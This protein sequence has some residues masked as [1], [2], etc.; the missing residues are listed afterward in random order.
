[1]VKSLLPSVLL[2]LTVA[3]A[4]IAP[5]AAHAALR[6]QIV[7]ECV[8]FQPYHGVTHQMCTRYFYDANGVLVNT[9]VYYIDESGM[10]YL[11]P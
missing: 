10:W 8:P 3:T 9:M 7:T 6:T 2:T 4:A 11:L 5:D 1:M